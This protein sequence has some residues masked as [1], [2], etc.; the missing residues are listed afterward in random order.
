M[1]NKRHRPARGFPSR[2]G[3]ALS[4]PRE[5][6]SAAITVLL[7]YSLHRCEEDRVYDTKTQRLPSQLAVHSIAALTVWF[8]YHTYSIEIPSTPNL[9]EHVSVAQRLDLQASQGPRDG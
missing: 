7:L 9:S 3:L 6:I 4:F 8:W 1:P 2:A 5:K